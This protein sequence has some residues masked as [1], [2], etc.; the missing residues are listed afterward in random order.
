[1]QRSLIL[2]TMFRFC[3]GTDYSPSKHD[4][5]FAGA[6]LTNKERSLTIVSW[7]GAAHSVW[8]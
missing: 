4:V 3:I 1:L 8:E 5:C 7:N 2:K 6:Q